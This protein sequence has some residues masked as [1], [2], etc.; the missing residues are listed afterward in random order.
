MQDKTG[1]IDRCHEIVDSL[2]NFDIK[3]NDY[4][5]YIVA[6]IN[7]HTIR[8]LNKVRVILEPQ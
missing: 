7:I 3:H 1:M 2:T 8:Q 4:V 6:I 5:T